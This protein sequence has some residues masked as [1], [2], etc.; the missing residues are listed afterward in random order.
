[1]RRRIIALSFLFLWF[2]SA[3]AEVQVKNLRLWHAPDHT[4]L[5][6]DLSGAVV[7]RGQ[8][9]AG[10]D[11]VAVDLDGAKLQGALP[12]L[13]YTGPYLRQVRSGQFTQTVL[14]LVLD[15][16]RTV[17]PR[18]ALLEPNSLYGYRL[19]IDLYQAG[20]VNA[21]LTNAKNAGD[22][23]AAVQPAS[24]IV[25]PRPSSQPPP[26][27]TP[28]RSR[29]F[30]V[31]IDAGHGG[32]DPGAIGRSGTREKNI[33][34][35]VAQE[36]KRLVDRDP[37][38]RSVMIRRGD[39]FV[40]LRGRTNLARNSQADVF[41]SIHADAFP[42]RSVRG[43]SVYALSAKG[44]SSEE[45]RWLADK[46][47][48]ADLIGGVSL[49]DKDDNL[50]YTLYD[51]QRNKTIEHSLELGH[52]V[53]KELGRVGKL[54]RGRVEQAGFVVLKSPDVPSIL[55]ETAFI[56]NPQEERALRSQRHRARVA[57]AIYSGLNRYRIRNR[58]PNVAA[59][60][61]EFAL[62]R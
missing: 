60:A 62:D 48:A 8:I 51:L 38:M 37:K 53:L 27:Q 13:T 7:F 11:R 47:N 29:Y 45:A 24:P 22:D 41:I 30:I 46:E 35:K 32:E 23:A 3:G 9:L 20:T 1:M 49:K 54:H 34:L 57:Q 52:D 58:L 42:Q 21:V 2:D 59:A 26:P 12:N 55:V 56:T 28:R 25:A 39:Y 61:E 31:A 4:R 16:K 50:A 19:V 5:V 15:L 14:R 36:L 33:T 17:S 18:I 10:P 6:F 40:S 43:S 44:A